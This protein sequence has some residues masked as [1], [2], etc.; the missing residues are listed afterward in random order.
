MF[1]DATDTD[2][3][4]QSHS[5][6][7]AGFLA[8]SACADQLQARA[9]GVCTSVLIGEVQCDEVQFESDL[10][11]LQLHCNRPS[12]DLPSSQAYAAF[13]IML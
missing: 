7:L 13:L 1:Q 5:E 12:G 2:P 10:Y 9:G 8:C 6:S 11:T 4:S 3:G